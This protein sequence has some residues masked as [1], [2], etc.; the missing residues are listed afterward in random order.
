MGIRNFLGVSGK[1]FFNPKAWV[2]YNSLKDHSLLIWSCITGIFSRGSNNTKRSDQPESFENTLV[3]LN[4]SEPELALIARR[5]LLYALWFLMLVFCDLCY[6][7]YLIWYHHAFASFLI[8]LALVVFLLAQVFKYHFWYF[9]IKQRRLG[10][11]FKQ[12]K[13]SLL[14]GSLKNQAEET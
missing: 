13:N 9:Q 11:T 1:T 8:S 12:W 7:I 5:N 10:C 6:A 3:K 14:T 4:I 2:G